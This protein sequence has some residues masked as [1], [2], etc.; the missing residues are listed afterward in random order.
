MSTTSPTLPPPS[1][2]SRPVLAWLARCWRNWRLRH[3]LPL[4]LALHLA[5][6]PLALAGLVLAFFS[7]PWG[8]AALALGYLLQWV[9]HR[10][11]GNDLGEWAAIKRLLGRPYVA[12]APRWGPQD[13]DRL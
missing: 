7:W 8:L 5:G 2:P 12:V 10:C 13:A 4:N 3:R 1:R 9:G 11:E 6:I